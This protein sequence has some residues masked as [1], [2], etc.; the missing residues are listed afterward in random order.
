[1]GREAKH[2]VELS[3]EERAELQEL[4]D[5]GRRSKTI[6]Q[7]AA[8]LLRADQGEGGLAWP[9]AKIAEALQV[10]LSTV[11]RARKRLVEAG[12]EVA[13][14]HQPSPNRQYRKLDGAQEAQLVKLACS[15]APAGR[16]KWTMALL[17]D[18]LV[19]LQV[20]GSIS[21]ETVRTT[22]KK[23]CSS[24]GWSS[25]GCCRRARTPTLSRRWRTCSKSAID[26]TTPSARRST[27]TSKAD[28]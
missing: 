26:R 18:R 11:E 20:V 2:I 25:N 12:F 10:G 23:T 3:A 4:V 28:N 9:D 13:L 24:P 6:R 1:M 19:Q 22:L 16:A 27:S 14:V 15:P 8:I 5:R 21:A 17:A 7:R